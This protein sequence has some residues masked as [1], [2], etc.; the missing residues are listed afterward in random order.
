M[1]EYI[2]LE[3]HERLSA[4]ATDLAVDAG[5]LEEDELKYRISTDIRSL[6]RCIGREAVKDFLSDYPLVF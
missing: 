6:E 2:S 1:Q 3:A 4:D 5:Q